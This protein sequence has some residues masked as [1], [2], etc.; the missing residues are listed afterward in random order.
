MIAQSGGDHGTITG[1]KPG[2]TF[3][4]CRLRT[5]SSS[6][7][8]VWRYWEGTKVILEDSAALR[9][10]ADLKRQKKATDLSSVFFKKRRERRRERG[11]EREGM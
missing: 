5:V 1:V 3:S 6:R 9:H 7:F 8:P 11:R 10:A 2:N 4:M